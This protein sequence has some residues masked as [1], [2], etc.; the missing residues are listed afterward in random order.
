MRDAG[1]AVR[2]LETRHVREAFKAMPGQD[3]SDDERGLPAERL[4]VPAVHCKSLPARK[5]RGA[6][7]GTQL[8]QTKNT[9][10]EMR[11]ARGATRGFGC[12]TSADDTAKFPGRDHEWSR[13]YTLLST[14]VEALLAARNTFSSNGQ[15]LEKR[16]R[17]MVREE[18]RGR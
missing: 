4:L 8:L 18:A 17:S 7:D 14:M 15:K 10:Y 3:R 11:P 2:T 6:A 12:E 1:L 13:Q 16:L 5:G 9:T